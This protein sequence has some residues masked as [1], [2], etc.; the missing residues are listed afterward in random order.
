MGS[1]RF[2][3]I[4]PD[5]HAGSVW[6]ATLLCLVYSVITLVLRGH[7]RWNMYGLDDYLALAATATQVGEVVAVIIGLD[8]G[9][10]KTQDLLRQ[11]ELSKAS[12]ATFAGQLLFIVAAAT[13]KA[14]TL[15]L[16]MRLFNLVGPRTGQRLQSKVLYWISL[17]I[18]VGVGLWG[19]LSIVALAVD[20]SISGFIQADTAQCSH[21][22]L[23]WQLIAAF[24]V[25]TECIL[26]AITVIVVWPVHLAFAM[27]CQVVLAFAFRLPVAMLS[28]LHLHYVA[29]YTSSGNPGIAIVPVIVIQQVQLC[30]SLISAT[31]PNL[32]SFVRSFSSGFGIQL[33]PSLTQAYYGSGRSS[34]RLGRGSTNAYE[35]ASVGGNGTAKSR[36]AA[37]S[38]NDNT[39]EQF[40]PVPQSGPGSNNLTVM[41][42]N[43]SIDSGGSQ[44]HIIRK[45]VQWNVHYETETDQRR[46]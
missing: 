42:E 29:D 2:S 3:P 24:D 18:L 30:W 37:R 22:F 1:N 16:M 27:K 10:G 36:S 5:D 33:D 7:L 17:V 32:K 44:D 46:V 41:R 9:L 20:C 15:C 21:Q 39:T 19:I 45:D 26:V 40:P 34:G 38:Y 13:A 35:M 8:H 43:D 12:R 4:T 23:R 25:A 28:I 6:I 11:S 31:I 14:S